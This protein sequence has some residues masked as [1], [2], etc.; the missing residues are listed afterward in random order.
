MAW[1]H[2]LLL[3]AVNI[4][5]YVWVGR[6]IFGSWRAFAGA[7]R[8]A[9]SPDEWTWLR[10]QAGGGAWDWIREVGPGVWL[11]A[12]TLTVVFEGMLVEMMMGA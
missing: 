9:V 12:C 7:L 11:L 8:Y 2:W 4:P 6:M 10:G 1:W 5:V 3:V